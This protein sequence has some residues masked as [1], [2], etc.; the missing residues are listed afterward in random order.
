MTIRRE[1]DES[2][3]SRRGF[4]AGASVATAATVLQSKT[5]LGYQANSKVSIGLIGSGGRGTWIANLFKEHGGYEI[6]AV[7][8]YFQDRVDAA[9]D[10]FGVDAS[11]RFTGLKG[12][13]K[14]L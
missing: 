4:I 1:K 12:Y 3:V 14:L 8:D 5:A 9:G 7:H 11:A 13:E 2:G 6:A 10:M